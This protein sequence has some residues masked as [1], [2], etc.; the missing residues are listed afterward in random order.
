MI[1]LRPTNNISGV[2]DVSLCNSIQTVDRSSIRRGSRDDEL[3]ESVHPSTSLQSLCFVAGP[4]RFRVG[5]QSADRG[6]QMDG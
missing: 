5:G 1:Y 2:S 4:T 3:T 6:G